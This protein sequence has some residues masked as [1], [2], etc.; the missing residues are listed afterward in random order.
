MAALVKLAQHS[1]EAL[2][3]RRFSLVDN[4]GCTTEGLEASLTTFGISVH[5]VENAYPC[6]RQQLRY[7][8]GEK[9]A[10]RGAT[11]RHIM[12]LPRHVSLDKFVTA[13]QR[14]V[15]A[16]TVLRTRIIG[17]E[18]RFGQV[19]LKESL[20]CPRINRLSLL[21]VED[22]KLSWALDQPQS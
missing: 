8:E 2:T 5:G 9:L 4:I 15:A 7:I 20:T 19:V 11:Y 12:P 16:N 21:D 1:I 13:L 6:T 14:V 17:I 22:R 18:S 10:P 3:L